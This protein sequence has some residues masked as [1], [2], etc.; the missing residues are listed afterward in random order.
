M[1]GG[2]FIAAACIMGE[3][4]SILIDLLAGLLVI[5]GLAGAL[6]PLLPGT[7]LVFAGLWLLAWQDQYQHVGALTLWLLAGLL[8]CS[9][10]IDQLATILGVQRAGASARAVWGALWGGLAGMF[11]G[12][13]GIL[14][15]PVVGALLGEWSYRRQLAQAGRVAVAAGVSFILASA[16]KLG[17]GLSMVG[18]FAMVWWW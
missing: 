9:L 2:L 8:I 1:I 4:Q 16:L 14:L 18:I 7:P 6:L 10:V 11:A 13:P 12:L 3:Y 5:A 15:G 17:L